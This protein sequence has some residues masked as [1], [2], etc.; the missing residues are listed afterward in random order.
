[1]V[2]TFPGRFEGKVVAITGGASGVGAAL[3]TRYVAE[4]AK[5]LVADFCAVEKGTAFVSQFP[6]DSVYFHRVDIGD[7]EEATSVVTMAITQFGRIDIV[8]NNASMFAWGTIPEMNPETWKRVFQ[9]G[10]DGPFYICRAA[11]PH[12]AKQGGGSIVNT[13]STTATIGDVGL[14]AYCAAK[15]A[16]GNL[17]RVMAA[18]HALENVR[19][20][21]VVPG[22]IDTPMSTSLSATP[23]VRALVAQSTPMRR[24]ADPR[25]IASVAM[26]LASDDASFVTGSLYT[27]DGGLTCQSRMPS[28]SE[29]HAAESEGKESLY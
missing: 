13:L 27:A 17:T 22:W 20:N 28:L 1:M 18:D 19:V 25:E 29:V 3:T 21:A 10:V 16:L 8:H 6:K 11:I 26:F 12:M 7:A 5:V 9:V 4:G 24:P 23:K 15:A 14:G 2:L